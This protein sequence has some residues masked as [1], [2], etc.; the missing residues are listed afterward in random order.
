MPVDF[1]EYESP[2][3]NLVKPGT[4]ASRIV[5]FLAQRSGTGFTP[6]EI[7]ERTDVPLGSVEPAL[8]RLQERGLVRHKGDYWA[9]A[10]DDRLLRLDSQIASLAAIDSVDDEWGDV[11]WDEEGVDENELEAWRA[12]QRGS[13]G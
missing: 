5:A 7:A 3:N 10:K 1:D 4:S 11:D 12:K 13:N 6:S 9:V 2:P 8:K